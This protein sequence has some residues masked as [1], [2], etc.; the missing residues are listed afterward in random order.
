[1]RKTVFYTSVTVVV[2]LASFLFGMT[3]T[4]TK[5]VL[6]RYQTSAGVPGY[7][8]TYGPLDPTFGIYPDEYHTREAVNREV[9][10]LINSYRIHRVLDIYEYLSKD[11]DLTNAIINNAL[12]YDIPVNLLFAIISTESDFRN[13]L[14]VKNQNGTADYGIMQCNSNTFPR[15]DGKQLLDLETNLRLGCEYLLKMKKAHGS[16]EMAVYRYNGIGSKAVR[17][18]VRVINMEREIDRVVNRYL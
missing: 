3:V 5:P 6:P 1:M 9:V 2:C 18:M 12:R 7:E 10:S 17:H 8:E 15:Y 4:D 11:R 16:W 14:V 13:D